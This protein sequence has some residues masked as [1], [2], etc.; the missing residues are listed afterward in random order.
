MEVKVNGSS[1]YIYIYV[2]DDETAKVA[3]SGIGNDV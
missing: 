2:R 1:I 3:A